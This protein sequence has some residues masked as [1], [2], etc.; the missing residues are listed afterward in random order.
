MAN[1]TQ[2]LVVESKD[3]KEVFITSLNGDRISLSQ[4]PDFYQNNY[5]GTVI[6]SSSGKVNVQG[7]LF[8]KA[9]F[10]T[11][12]N[13]TTQCWVR[14]YNE[15]V[16]VPLSLNDSDEWVWCSGGRTKCESKI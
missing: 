2:G 4:T 9:M 15:P 13:H 7:G 5:I 14:N 3:I 12:K 10:K 8:E 16:E 11:A 1:G 6:L